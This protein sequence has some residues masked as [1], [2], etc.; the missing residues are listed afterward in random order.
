MKPMGAQLLFVTSIPSPY[1]FDFFNALEV[2]AP[3][4]FSVI[5]SAAQEIDRQY[6]DVPEEFSFRA[7]ILSRKTRR[8]GKDFH[9]SAGLK[10]ALRESSAESV[11]VGGNYFMPD[12]RTARS[13]CLRRG[14]QFFF[15]GENPFKRQE[16]GPKRWVKERYLKWFFGP[17]SGVI[18]IGEV[19]SKEYERLCKRARGVSIPYSPDLNSLLSPSAEL[20]VAAEELRVARGCKPTVSILYVGSLI[21]RKDPITLLKSFEFLATKYPEVQL[22]IVGEGQ[23]QSELK[24]RVS[25]NGLA[26]RVMFLGFLRDDELRAAYLAADL[27]VLPTVGHEG[28]GVVIQEAMAAGLPVIAS[29]RVGAAEDLLKSGHGGR[30]FDPGSVESLIGLLTELIEN[31]ELRTEL[32]RR[33]RERVRSTS[34]ESAARKLL[35]FLGSVP[36]NE[37]I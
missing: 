25:E 13:H 27:F 4:S 5:F 8:F 32:G 6:Y 10:A 24:A 14:K 17:A 3:G 18:G 26:E 9:R 37:A 15:W 19:A 11:I 16:M 35:K 30:L 28:W 23:L 36:G 21:P 22:Q 29:S 12:A 20:R 34:A 31:D 7:M 2:L 33:A 1:Q